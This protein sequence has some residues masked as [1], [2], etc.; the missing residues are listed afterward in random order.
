MG[1]T[2]KFAH[3]VFQTPQLDTMRDW[4]CDVLE[5]HAVYQGHGLCFVT[6]DE[7][8]HR[9]AFMQPPVNLDRKTPTTS[10]MHHTAYTFD[11]LDDLLERYSA[12][13]DKGIEPAVPIQHGV[14]TSLYYRDPDGNFVELQV[15]NFAAANDATAYM[16]GEEYD[17]DPVGVS[18]SP[19][20]MITERRNGVPA[21]Q[22]QTRTWALATTP[23]LPNPL[24]VLTS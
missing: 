15:D 2:P 5:G 18:F 6:F 14:T 8:H 17:R 16:E 10:G 19:D 3:V 23:D 9:V 11:H 24:E 4:Y 7:E 1:S 20:L 13:K 22:L 12:L 21:E